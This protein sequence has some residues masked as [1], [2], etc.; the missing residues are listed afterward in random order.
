MP[1]TYDTSLFSENYM[2]L[3]S[4]RIR[5]L[6]S[7][8][9]NFKKLVCSENTLPYYEIVRF[10]IGGMPMMGYRLSNGGVSLRV[11]DG[12]VINGLSGD[13]TLNTEETVLNGCNVQVA[14]NDRNEFALKLHKL[15]DLSNLPSSRLNNT[16]RTTNFSGVDWQLDEENSIVI[17]VTTEQPDDFAKFMFGNK[18]LL[19]G[20]LRD[21]WSPIAF[22]D[23]EGA[24][25][26]PSVTDSLIIHLDASNTSSYP[27]SGTTWTDLAGTNHA[28]ISGAT[29]SNTDG[30]IFDFDG[31]NDSVSI[32]HTSSLSLSTSAQKTIQAWVKF[33]VL[34]SALQQVPVFGKLS[35]SYGFDGYWA[36]LYNNTGTVR[37]V[38]NGTGTQRTAD[39]TSTITTN[40]WYLFTFISQIT[41]TANTTKVYINGTEYIST[42][43]GADTYSESNP[44]YIG[45]IGSGVGS[46]YLNGKIGAFYFYT[47]GLTAQEVQA[48]YAST[49]GRY[50]L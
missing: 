33:D 31:T 50:G 12:S 45:Y 40:T 42:D 29:W 1:F 23:G 17:D 44:L 30:G 25:Y 37:C 28:T 36:G 41:N 6:N 18:M 22:I 5:V 34:P 32:P 2:M 13:F 7:H 48:N 8:N 3:G 19:C 43:H 16:M 35:N 26:T 49:K 10:Y 46:S 21:G 47:K 11:I 20:L 15:S 9:Y 38:T 14:A 27:G 4:S 39:S 24:S